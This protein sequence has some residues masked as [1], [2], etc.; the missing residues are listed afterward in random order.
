MRWT[1]WLCVGALTLYSV[2]AAAD[3]AKAKAKGP[4]A[5][6]VS[7][8]ASASGAP[9][10]A[11]SAASAASAQGDARGKR[12]V[13]TPEQKKRHAD[14]MMATGNKIRALLEKDRKPVTSSERAIIKKHWRIA[15]RLLKVQRIAEG[16]NKP[17]KA[18]R[19][20]EV[21]AKEDARFYAKLE[22]MNK[23]AAAAA[24]SAS[25]PAPSGGSK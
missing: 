20:A 15:L 8:A 3:D 19:A 2:S 12:H 25:P 11:A 7:A 14:Y 24:V 9:G 4:H 23:V 1:R 13:E 6:R 16:Q 10:S 21:L 17:D 22:E 18:K 5:G